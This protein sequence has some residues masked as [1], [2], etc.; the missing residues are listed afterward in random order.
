[1]DRVIYRDY[2]VNQRWGVWPLQQMVQRS[3][4]K[5][6]SKNSEKVLLVSGYF[7]LCGNQHFLLIFCFQD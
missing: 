6:L 7:Q 2:I 4:H 5:N 1:M 3:C